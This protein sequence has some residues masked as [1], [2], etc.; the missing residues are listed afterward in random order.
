MSDNKKPVHTVNSSTQGKA[1]E[2]FSSQSVSSSDVQRNF[3]YALGKIQPKDPNSIAHKNIDTKSSTT[4]SIQ[5]PQSSKNSN[6]TNTYQTVAPQN[7][8]QSSS[9]KPQMAAQDLSNSNLNSNIN[10]PGKQGFQSSQQV[11]AYLN[12]PAGIQALNKIRKELN[13]IEFSKKQKR[14]SSFKALLLK[15]ISLLLGLVNKSKKKFNKLKMKMKEQAELERLKLIVST[16]PNKPILNKS[17]NLQLFEE[18]STQL[19]S[20]QKILEDLTLELEEAKTHKKALIQRYEAY[21]DELSEVTDIFFALSQQYAKQ[22]GK[23]LSVDDIEGILNDFLSQKSQA[24]SKDYVNFMEKNIN[25]ARAKLTDKIH[26][27]LDRLSL[28]T[29]DKAIAQ[30]LTEHNRLLVHDEACK[31]LVRIL[32][33]EKIAYDVEGKPATSMENA[34]FFVPKEKKLV[35][36]NNEYYLINSGEDFQVILQNDKSKQEA[37]QAYDRARG[38][39]ISLQLLVLNNQTLEINASSEKVD[40]LKTRKNSAETL[41]DSLQQRAQTELQNQAQSADLQLQDILQAEVQHLKSPLLESSNRAQPTPTPTFKPSGSGGNKDKNQKAYLSKKSRN[42]QPDNDQ[43]NVLNKLKSIFGIQPH[44]LKAHIDPNDPQNP[45][46]P[47]NPNNK[48]PNKNQF[49]PSPFSKN[50]YNK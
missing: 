47:Q 25:L 28:I 44:D 29:D 11:A 40:N 12:S 7:E 39:L 31:D 16:K 14:E 3:P 34:C 46:H 37:R 10:S 32:K 33:G 23:E 8:K 5:D 22:F 17:V 43:N 41:V 6:S 13:L 26:K 49:N 50:P 21:Q 36:Y 48:N 30:A 42:I 19:Y 27:T 15:K 20:Q 1:F 45:N 4:K 38:D 18:L 2:P 9:Q 35:F 24:D